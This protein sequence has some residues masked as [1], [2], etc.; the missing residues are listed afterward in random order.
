M[1]DIRREQNIVLA[2]SP[3]TDDEDARVAVLGI[4][5]AAWVNMQGDG[6]HTLDLTRAGIPLKLILF[7]AKD[8]ADVMKRLGEM[9]KEVT[10]QYNMVPREGKN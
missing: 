9:T 6:E 2:W 7:G 3:E 8:H 4:S 10:P 1:T 5:R